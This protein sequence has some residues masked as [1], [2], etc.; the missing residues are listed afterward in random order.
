MLSMV[1]GNKFFMQNGKQ[2]TGETKTSRTCL[3]PFFLRKLISNHLQNIRNWSLW[4]DFKRNIS[5]MQ[6]EPFT[7]KVRFGYKPE[8][9]SFQKNYMNLLMKIDSMFKQKI[10]KW[11]AMSF[12]CWTKRSELTLGHFTRKKSPRKIW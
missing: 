1:C 10:T 9:E 3:Y 2:A 11:Y 12:F 4:C 7:S 5:N 8:S 6:N